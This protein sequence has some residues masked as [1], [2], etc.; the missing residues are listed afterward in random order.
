M[1]ALPTDRLDPPVRTRDVVVS[2]ASDTPKN[3]KKAE[4]VKDHLQSTAPSSILDLERLE[5]SIRAIRKIMDNVSVDNLLSRIESVER[6]IG[7]LQRL[8]DQNETQRIEP[9]S[10]GLSERTETDAILS[11]L[12]DV[13]DSMEN[14]SV[15][16]SDL[17][18]RVQKVQK[19]KQR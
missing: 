17:E 11:R 6:G 8:I 7:D 1:W 3:T 16:L 2:L 15:R 12:K 14:L 18:K 10:P 13:V 4:K 19:V 9:K 5:E